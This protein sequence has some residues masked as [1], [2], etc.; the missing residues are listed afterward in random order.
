MLHNFSEVF[1]FFKSAFLQDIKKNNLLL[2]Q[3]CLHE[4]FFFF[5]PKLFLVLVFVLDT[6]ISKLSYLSF[7]LRF[8]ST[9]DPVRA[10]L[11]VRS[12]AEDTD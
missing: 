5:G 3:H 4:V 10:A 12:H 7:F 8:E 2:N 6:H 1:F 11:L 9:F